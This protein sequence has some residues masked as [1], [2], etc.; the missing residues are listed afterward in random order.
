MYKITKSRVTDHAM[1]CWSDFITELKSITGLVVTVMFF[2]WASTALNAQVIPCID[3]NS[4]EWGSPAMQ[5]EPTYDLVHDVFTGNMDD[6]YTGSKDFKLFG[7]NGQEYNGW[8]LS[9]MQAKS[10][11]MNASAVIL[12][13]LIP[14]LNSG[15]CPGFGTTP[16]EESHTYLFFAGDRESNLGVGYIGFWFLLDGSAPDT[17]AGGKKIFTPEHYTNMGQPGVTPA[18]SVGDLLILANF[19]DGGRNGE[20]TVLK[21]VGAGNGNRGNNNSLF[22]ITTETQVGQNNTVNTPVP[23]GWIVPAGQTTYDYNEFYEGVVDLTPIFDLVANP[24]LLCTARW[25]LETRASKEIEADLKDFVAGSF[26]LTPDVE[27]SNATVC[28]GENAKLVATVKLNTQ[29]QTPGNYNYKWYTAADWNDGNAANNVDIGDGTHELKFNPTTLGDAGDY[30]LVVTPGDIAQCDPE[31]PQIGKLTINVGPDAGTGGSD[32]WCY[33]DGSA[34]YNLNGKVTGGDAG[35]SWSDTDASGVTLG[36]GSS[37]NFSALGAGVYHYKYTV[38]PAEGSTCDPDDT[39]V[40][41]TIDD[42]V[43]AGT[44]GSDRWC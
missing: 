21:W 1:S 5:L 35:G 43:D 26:H 4:T 29:V 6:I 37:V 24:K 2:L 39:T 15:D 16:Y 19:V 8:T 3:G 40:T 7:A 32:R 42:P 25:M 44:G 30:Y 28:E 9:P 34:T 38:N 22:E 17:D 13:G 11:I 33:G 18:N 31:F 36:D 23:P 41:I 10:D 12:T 20:V 27:V 14:D